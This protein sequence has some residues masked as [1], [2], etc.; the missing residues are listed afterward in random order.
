MSTP[1]L[2]VQAPRRVAWMYWKPFW[3]AVAILGM[4]VAVLIDAVWGAD[5]VAT[6]NTGDTRS[7]PAAIPIAFFVSIA[8]VFVARYGFRSDDEKSG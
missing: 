6:S 1:Q 8:T 4:W 2:A 5:I 3:A 7:F